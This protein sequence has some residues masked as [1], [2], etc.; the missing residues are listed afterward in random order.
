MLSWTEKASLVI[1]PSQRDRVRSWPAFCFY[2]SCFCFCFFFA[3]YSMKFLANSNYSDYCIVIFVTFGMT[4]WSRESNPPPPPPPL[5]YEMEQS[6]T[7][8][9]SHNR[10][11]IKL[12]SADVRFCSESVAAGQGHRLDTTNS[13]LITALYRWPYSCDVSRLISWKKKK[14]FQKRRLGVLVS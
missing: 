10:L 3:Q 7:L 14:N 4:G 13:L 2:L 9:K 12:T 5:S 6:S 8:P 11:L 1:E